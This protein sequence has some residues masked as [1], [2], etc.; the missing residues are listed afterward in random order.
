MRSNAVST[1]G[2]K[3]G[4]H[5]KSKKTINSKKKSV[6]LRDRYD[7]R[8]LNSATDD[9]KDATLVERNHSIVN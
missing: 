2:N 9:S 5:Y 3:A 8:E 7:L 6:F 1:S 4:S